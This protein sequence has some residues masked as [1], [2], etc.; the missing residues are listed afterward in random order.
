MINL[1]AYIPAYNNEATIKDAI[2]SLKNQSYKIEDIFIIDDGS[3]DQ[4]AHIAQNCGIKVVFNYENMGRGFTRSK[5][6][7]LAKHDI[8]VCCDATNELDHNF[9]WDGITAFNDDSVASVFGKITSKTTRGIVNQWR[10]THLFKEKADYGTGFKKSNLFITY[11][12]IVR[13]THI[14]NVGNFN[15]KLRHSEDEDLGERL[16]QNGYSLLSNHDLIVNCNVEN[17]LLE[18]L[19]R[20]WRWYI[21]KNE[22]MTFKDYLHSIKNSIKPMA[23]E[24]L[25][26]GNWSCIPISLFCPHYCL[27]KTLLTRL[28]NKK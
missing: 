2:N 14:L 18:V 3:S 7:S 22:K 24:D 19:E 6:M 17:S 27:F 15:P 16:I 8:V 26:S 13:K 20:Y 25:N 11:G 9:V 28:K 21:G 5:A 4:T 1:S 12:T 10:S 23:Q